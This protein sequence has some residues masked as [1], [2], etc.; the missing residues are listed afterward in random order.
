M[1]RL[2]VSPD[3]VSDIMWQVCPVINTECTI[4]CTLYLYVHCFGTLY[5]HGHSCSQRQCLGSTLH[6]ISCKLHCACFLPCWFPL[7]GVSLAYL[8]SHN[9]HIYNLQYLKV[10]GLQVEGSILAGSK[11]QGSNLGAPYMVLSHSGV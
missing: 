7:N 6:S 10:Y 11:L 3:Q 1:S 8:I 9:Q 2:T 4:V 5:R